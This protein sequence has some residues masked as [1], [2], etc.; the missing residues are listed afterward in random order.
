MLKRL[1]LVAVFLCASV[2]FADECVQGLRVDAKYMGEKTWVG[3]IDS[4][5]VVVEIVPGVGLVNKIVIDETKVRKAEK[6]DEG[7]FII[8]GDLDKPTF[9]LGPGAASDEVE[10]QSVGKAGLQYA[11]VSEGNIRLRGPAAFLEAKVTRS[12]TSEQGQQS[13]R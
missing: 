4:Y 1:I 2:S 13:Q 6:Q 10:I 7:A 11:N 3:S 5:D 9:V 12:C 8:L